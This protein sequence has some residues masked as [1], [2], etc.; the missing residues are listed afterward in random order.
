MAIVQGLV[1]QRVDARGRHVPSL[2][3]RRQE[4]GECGSIAGSVTRRLI[5]DQR[6]V[7]IPRRHLPDRH[8]IFKATNVVLKTLDVGCQWLHRWHMSGAAT[9]AR[10]RENTDVSTNGSILLSGKGGDIRWVSHEITYQTK[11]PLRDF[12]EERFGF[13]HVSRAEQRGKVKLVIGVNLDITSTT[14]SRYRCRS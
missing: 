10:P 13:P 1:N 14:P 2:F 5:E 12:T 8:A 9:Q 4:R 6:G 11:N 3:R 7:G